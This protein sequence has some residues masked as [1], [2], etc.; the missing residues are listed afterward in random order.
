MPEV[1]RPG[2]DSVATDVCREILDDTGAECVI[3]YGSRGWGEQSDTN[4]IMIHEAAAEKPEADRLLSAILRIKNRHYRDSADYWADLDSLSD[5][6][7]PITAEG[8]H[9]S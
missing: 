1:V 6:C 5:Q 2:T 7:L 8:P 4:V 9:K 3:L